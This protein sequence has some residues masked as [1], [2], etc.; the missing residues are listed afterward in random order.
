MKLPIFIII[1]NYP[2]RNSNSLDIV[3]VE[4]ILEF[5]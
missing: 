4:V 1:K 5:V 3:I 2:K